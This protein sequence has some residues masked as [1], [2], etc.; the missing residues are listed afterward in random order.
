MNKAT[1]VD[2]LVLVVMYTTDNT[3]HSVVLLIKRVGTSVLC[4]YLC[5][6]VLHGTSVYLMVHLCYVCTFMSLAVIPVVLQFYIHLLL[7]IPVVNHLT[8]MQVN[9]A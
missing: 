2:V 1:V 5:V 4:V 7:I 3:K 9:V 8:C 6:S